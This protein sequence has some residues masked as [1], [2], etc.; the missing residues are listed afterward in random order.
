VIETD[1]ELAQLA[2]EAPGMNFRRAMA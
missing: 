1:R 2:E